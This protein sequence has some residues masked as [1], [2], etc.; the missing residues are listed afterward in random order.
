MIV[1][2]CGHADYCRT[3]EHEQKILAFLEEKIGNQPADIY[4]GG[5]GNFDEFAYDLCKE[6]KKSHSNVSLQF[7]TP[8]ISES[9]QRN[10]LK[11]EKCRYDG[12]I[13]PEIEYKPPRF[14]IS[15]RNRWMV[16]KADFVVAYINH[17]WGGAYK[18]YVY[19]KEKEKIIFNLG[20]I[21]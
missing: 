17:E 2:F 7:I 15:Y 11:Y 8:Y 20:E 10:R 9:Y 4:L 13:Y 16:E 5:Y 19:A 6:Y 1:T 14:A 3:K 21:Q 12:I 18:T